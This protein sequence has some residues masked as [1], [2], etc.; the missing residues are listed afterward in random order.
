MDFP[1][2]GPATSVTPM[3]PTS[4]ELAQWFS[5]EIQPH[6]PMLRA[7]L[8]QRFPG[9][10]DVDDLVQETYVRIF[11]SEWA[12]RLQHPKSYIY[13]VARNAA[14]DQLR[15]SKICRIEGVAEFDDVPATEE[16]GTREAVRAEEDLELLAEAIEALPERCRKILKLRKLE[17]LSYEEIGRVMGISFNTVNA[18]LVVGLARCRAYVIER[19]KG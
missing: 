15:R 10:S 1:A 12:G 6:E 3:P 14:L 4:P 8:R 9:V 11:R 19:S 2:E 7:W 13:K 18:Q 16:R 5:R 17:G